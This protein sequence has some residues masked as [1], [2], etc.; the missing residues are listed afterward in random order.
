MEDVKRARATVKRVLT[1]AINSV[2]SAVTQALDVDILKSR[3]KQA[4]TR[5]EKVIDA[6]Q[7][8]EIAYPNDKPI[9][10]EDEEWMKVI[11]ES[12]DNTEGIALTRVKQLLKEDE[13]KNCR[14]DII[15]RCSSPAK[16][17]KAMRLRRNVTRV[18]N[19]KLFS[20]YI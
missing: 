10:A 20:M 16:S 1:M 15:R 14:K 9:S 5:M 8:L 3:L 7:Y 17:P 19:R 6:Y 13:T 18:S 11:T 2:N 12:Y 4:D